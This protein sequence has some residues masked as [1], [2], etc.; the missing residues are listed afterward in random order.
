VHVFGQKVLPVID[1]NAVALVEEFTRQYD[2]AGIRSYN[3]L[4]F[5][6]GKV[7]AAMLAGEFFVQKPRHAE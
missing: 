4:A 2:R 1:E 7:R 6:D 3:R 5:F